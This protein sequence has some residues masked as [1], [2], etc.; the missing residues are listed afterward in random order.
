MLTTAGS[1][2]TEQLTRTQS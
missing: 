1:V 2:L